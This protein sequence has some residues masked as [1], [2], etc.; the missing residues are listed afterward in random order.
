M[1]PDYERIKTTDPIVMK[2]L[3]AGGTLEDV[4]VTLVRHAEEA[5]ALFKDM[6]I[7]STK[8]MQPPAPE[9][10]GLRLRTAAQGLRP[11]PF[12]G[13]S[14]A[15]PMGVGE[16]SM[17]VAVVCEECGAQGPGPCGDTEGAEVLWNASKIRIGGFSSRPP[18]PAE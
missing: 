6:E 11:C 8:L 9:I 5:R 18:A 14:N 16:D 4:I 1:N 15:R 17:D 13:S 3:A 2:V 7:Q 12:C 10:E